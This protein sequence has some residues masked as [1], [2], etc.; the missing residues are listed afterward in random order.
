MTQNN[1]NLNVPIEGNIPLANNTILNLNIW[2]IPINP[3]EDFT[4]ILG[5]FQTNLVSP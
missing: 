3:T 4:L 1:F 2:G 5:T